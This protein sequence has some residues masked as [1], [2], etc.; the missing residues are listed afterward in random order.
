MHIVMATSGLD[1]FLQ[2]LIAIIAFV[3][4]LLLTYFTTKFIG[5]YQKTNSVGTNFE[6][7][8][9]YR[10]SN[11]KYLQIL[12]I[13]KKYVVIA[14][15]KDTVISIAELDEEDITIPEYT[16]SQESFAKVLDKLKKVY[17][18]DTSSINN[19]PKDKTEKDKEDNGND[20]S[21]KI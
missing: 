2:L 6:M 17:S 9:T 13:G 12:R 4:V 10:I 18:K 21:D 16:S 11:T 5:N 20:D 8:E 3:I 15:C 7:I 19:D 14:V 1:N